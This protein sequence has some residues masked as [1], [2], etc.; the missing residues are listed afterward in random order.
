MKHERC[1]LNLID[2]TNKE[3]E[4]QKAH[5]SRKLET[6]VEIKSTYKRKLLG[7]DVVL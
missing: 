4:A 1:E 7:K 3:L 6:Q 2:Q 5:C